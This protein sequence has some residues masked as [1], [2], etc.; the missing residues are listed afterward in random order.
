MFYVHGK[1][2]GSVRSA[3]V[4]CDVQLHSVMC[5]DTVQCEVILCDVQ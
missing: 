1:K 3:V 2:E 5:S 4:L